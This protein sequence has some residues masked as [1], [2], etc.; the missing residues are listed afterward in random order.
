MKHSAAYYILRKY[1]K[2]GHSTESAFIRWHNWLY[3]VAYSDVADLYIVRS[4]ETGNSSYICSGEL[5]V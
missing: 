3:L 4:L 1:F 2:L 5:E